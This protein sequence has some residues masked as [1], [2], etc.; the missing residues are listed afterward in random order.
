MTTELDEYYLVKY[1]IVGEPGV[2]K[3]SLAEYYVNGKKADYKYQSTMGVSFYSVDKI[4]NEKNIKLYIWDTAGQERF[5]SIVQ[6]YYRE[7]HGAFICFSLDRRHTFRMVENKINNIIKYNHDNN[8]EYV[9]VGTHADIVT[10]KDSIRAI[11]KEEAQSL[12][13]KYNMEYIEI[14]SKNGENINKCFDIMNNL[15]SEH[16]DNMDENISHKKSYNIIKYGN[17]SK[18]CCKNS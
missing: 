17:K 7:A 11:E 5:N 18:Y 1:I 10:G 3:T 16:I 14:S 12:A 13:K 2:G 8:V 9:L 6:S 4:I 15:M